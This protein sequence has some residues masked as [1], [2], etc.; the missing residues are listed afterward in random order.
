VIDS[1]WR[2]PRK[3]EQAPLAIG[4]MN[5][6]KRTPE[7]EA[8]KIVARAIERGFTFFDTAN[9]YDNGESERILGRALKGRRA[10]SFIASKVGF[11]RVDGKQEG[12]SPASVARACEGSLSRLGTDYLDVY[13]LHVPD[14]ETPIASTLE[15]IKALLD[16]GKVRHFG[17]SNYASWQILEIF[18]LCD[19]AGMP[20]PVLSQ[21]LYN[22]LIRQLDIEYFKFTR[23]YPIHTTVYNA[24]AGGMLARDHDKNEIPR[25][26]RFDK[27]ALYQRR[28]WSDTMFQFVAG[29]RAVAAEEGCPLA[30]LTY[31]WLAHRPGIDSVLVGPATVQQ[32]DM[33]IDAAARV[34]S[35]QASQKFDEL[36]R[37]F[38][39]TDATY[40]R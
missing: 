25:G 22:P 13:Y 10:S 40:A 28:Y 20:R 3:T 16:A 5:F 39:G 7:A 23:K 1:V 4:T 34:P 15:A 6:G 38:A 24:L 8:K 30:E 31:A 19:A 37:A 21:Q 18:T 27:N 35:S 33:A 29:L 26:S 32:L 14:A 17:I 11:G 9:V 12:L 36:Y 2:E